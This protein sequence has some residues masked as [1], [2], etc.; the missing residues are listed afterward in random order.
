MKVKLNNVRL[1][2][3]ALFTPKAFSDDQEAKYGASFIIAKTNTTLVGEV[4]KAIDAVIQDKWKGKKPSGLKVCLRDGDEKADTDGYGDEVVF[5]SASSKKR[6]PIVDR[7]LSPIDEADA[8][9]YAGCYVNATVELWAQ[10]NK[11]GK[12]VNA[13]LKAVQFVRDGEAFG[14]KGVNPEEEFTKLEDDDS[15]VL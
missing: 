3:P 8:K 10:D 13:Q 11:W 6:I 1:S 5:I 7:D 9:I 14:D 2:F 12:R 4:K 15:G